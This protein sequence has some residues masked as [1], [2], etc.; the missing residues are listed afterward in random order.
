MVFSSSSQRCCCW[1]G[2]GMLS[3]SRFPSR[4]L[5]RHLSLYHLGGKNTPD[6]PDNPTTSTYC[7]QV[8]PSSSFPPFPPPFTLG[9]KLIDGT[10]LIRKN[11]IACN[12]LA[13]PGFYSTSHPTIITTTTTSSSSSSSSFSTQPVITAGPLSSQ[14]SAFPLDPSRVKVQVCVRL[15][16]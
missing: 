4:Q 16:P 15:L 9:E 14:A 10:A 5:V 11:L 7:N 2:L 13:V 3:S 6:N 12:Y 1:V 8:F